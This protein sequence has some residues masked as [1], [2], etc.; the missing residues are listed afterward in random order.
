MREIFTLAEPVIIPDTFVTEL[1][2]IERFGST[3]RLVFT[4]RI[5]DGDCSE[6]R[7]VCRLIVPAELLKTICRQIEGGEPLPALGA[8]PG[9]RPDA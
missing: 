9:R 1:S 7:V 8:M 2:A 3:A 4:S 6:R 5:F